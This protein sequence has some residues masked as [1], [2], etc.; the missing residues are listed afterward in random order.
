MRSP[1]PAARLRSP[2][3]LGQAACPENVA[4]GNAPAWAVPEMLWPSTVALNVTVI[5]NGCLMSTFQVA[6][7][8]VDASV[9]DVGLLAAARLRAGQRAAV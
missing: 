9:V 7:S 8:P 6:L 3:R 5:A 4:G 2:A 1:Q